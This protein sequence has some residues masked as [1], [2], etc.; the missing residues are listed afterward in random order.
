VRQK[1]EHRARERAKR[2]EVVGLEAFGAREE[3]GW[4]RLS[5]GAVSREDIRGLMPRLKV[6]LQAVK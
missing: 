3:T 2:H 1:I 4:F 6:A 5:V